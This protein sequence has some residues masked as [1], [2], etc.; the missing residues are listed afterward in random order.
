MDISSGFSFAK[1]MANI[2]R[3]GVD[4]IW[5]LRNVRKARAA[6]EGAFSKAPF[7]PR[8]EAR[9]EFQNEVPYV[10]LDGSFTMGEYKRIY[11]CP[12]CEYTTYTVYIVKSA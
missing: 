2:Y 11:K 9:M 4:M 1:F 12:L 5:F 6:T 8:H 7:C 3:W 10:L